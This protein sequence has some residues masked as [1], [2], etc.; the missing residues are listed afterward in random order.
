MRQAVEKSIGAL[1]TLVLEGKPKGAAVVLFHGYGADYT[2]LIPLSEMMNLSPDVTWIFPNAPNEVIVA[3]G[4][5]GRAWFQIDTQRLEESIRRGEPTDMSNSTP[6]GLEG[7]RKL[8]ANFY[9]EV[10]KNYSSIVLGGFSQGAMLATELTL[11]HEQKPSALVIL[12]GALLCQSRWKTMAATCNGLPFFQS[13]GKNDPLLGFSGAESLHELL[14]EAGLEGDIYQFS[15][16]HEIPPKV[17]E[18]LAQFLRGRTT[19]SK[20]LH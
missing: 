12:S 8:A 16:G 18:K 4:F 13:H 2:D 10:L 6:P 1:K 9:S 3:P 14:T 20:T 17:I 19:L 15:G 11:S 7:A 5:Y